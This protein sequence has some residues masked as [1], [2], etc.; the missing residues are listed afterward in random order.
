M[1]RSSEWQAMKIEFVIIGKFN[2]LDH[3]CTYLPLIACTYLH[4]STWPLG[5][6]WRFLSLEVGV[7]RYG[8]VAL[9]QLL[10]FVFCFCFF[11]R[12]RGSA[13]TITWE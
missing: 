13:N 9:A 11:T 8:G 10:F 4:D 7:I 2:T 5:R 3:G 12:P 6:F 1:W